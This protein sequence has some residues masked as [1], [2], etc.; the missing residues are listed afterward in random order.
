MAMIWNP[1]SGRY[2]DDNAGRQ[3]V[4]SSYVPNTD[5]FPGGPVYAPG[6][7]PSF[8]VAPAAPPQRDYLDDALGVVDDDRDRALGFVDDGFDQ[9]TAADN[10]AIDNAGDLGNWQFNNNSFNQL[11][12]ETGMGQ[13]D[14]PTVIGEDNKIKTDERAMGEQYGIL[15]TLKG[16]AT[17]Q[18]TDGDRARLRAAQM[19]A[20]I[21]M[22]AA[23]GATSRNLQARGQYGG[24]AELAMLNMGA[25][26]AENQKL[27]R[28]LGMQQIASDR[29]LGAANAAG[30]L[31]S[32]IRE[33]SDAISTHN[34]EQEFKYAELTA[35]NQQKDKDRGV[36]IENDLNDGRTKIVDDRTKAGFDQN[37]LVREAG[38]NAAKGGLA[39]AAVIGGGTLLKTDLFGRKAGAAELGNLETDDKPGFLED[40]IGWLGSIF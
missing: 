9:Q 14:D 5:P 3:P 2:E 30:D 17:G 35:D 19:E 12:Y 22:G 15:D 40:P 10:W 18:M 1:L 6:S 37:E 21:G 33:Q 27:M 8:P 36:K 38:Q 13:Y 34:D 25:Q 28:E 4:A 11:K 29:A 16:M 32:S 7:G 23:R 24:G 39:R 26:D 31:S 20:D